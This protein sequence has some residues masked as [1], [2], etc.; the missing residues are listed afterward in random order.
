MP[1]T[2][3]TLALA[4]AL[5]LALPTPRAR[6]QAPD[7]AATPPDSACVTCPRKRP[8]VAL[9]ETFL[10]N[11]LVNR[12][13]AWIADQDWARVGLNSW[14][15]NLRLGWEWDE[16]EFATNM[17]AHPYH[18][19]L[20]FNAGRSNGFSYWES[21]PLAFVG[22]WTWEYLGETYRPSLN[23]YFMTT[24]GG[25]T[26]G[27]VFHRVG[28]SIR[29]NRRSGTERTL[30]EI[31]ALPFDPVG[32]FNRL[33]RGEW[34]RLG[35]NPDAH[36]EGTY[37]VRLGTGWRAAADTGASDATISSGTLLA[38]L[39]YGDRY[40]RAY[41]APFDV[42]SLRA[43]VS[44]G[45]LN[46][47][48]ASG[49]LYG[50][51]ITRL[52]GRHP[53]LIE[54][55]QRYDFVNN[56]AFR[57]GAQSVEAGLASRW[58]LGSFG[59]RTDFFA[60]GIILGAL[61][62]PYGGVGERTYDF[63]PGAGFRAEFALE[64]KGVTFLTLIGRTEYVH[65][66][67][68]A[69]ADHVVG[70]GG[71]EADIPLARGLGAGVHAV[72]YSRRSRYA[73]GTVD[74]REF[75]ELRLLLN[76]TRNVRPSSTAP[77]VVDASSS[78]APPPPREPGRPTRTVRRHGLWG[79]VGG[80]PA[81]FRVGCSSCVG[82]VTSTG[83]G[84]YAR[85]GWAAS[86]RVLMGV[87]AYGFTDEGFGFADGDTAVVATSGTASAIALWYPWRRAPVFVKG[88]VGI[89]QGDFTVRPDTGAAVVA[90]GLGVGLT[91]GLGVDLPVSRRLAITGNLGAWITAIG[92]IALPTGT[93][94]DPIP[95]SY[96]LSVGVT[97]R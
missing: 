75:P 27:E 94:D 84:G 17:F 20:Y 22:S 26:L 61:D 12:Y 4:C 86:S 77:A 49:R 41:R 13:N 87:E 25:I 70:F 71:F 5:T 97:F 88:G 28:S 9:G 54:V 76:W 85:L 82:V 21:V 7:T 57:F 72:Y 45:G 93:V 1:P 33:L 48:R 56:P 79:E 65:S 59:L 51:D 46:V 24:F 62:A 29:D 6:A 81:R 39:N 36:D 15:R 42:F 67:S 10:V 38:E 37:L 95:A 52:G 32:G 92:D 53:Q 35:P 91:F 47:L 64:R 34:T 90:E 2:C 44:S 80:G 55:N 73:D 14:S 60:D 8:L 40:E 66:V 83:S 50:R 89:A 3:R 69:E 16:D 43:Q 18:G 11:V 78:A 31:A 96:M 68:G 74:Q 58:R 23:D 19:A 30:R 63:G